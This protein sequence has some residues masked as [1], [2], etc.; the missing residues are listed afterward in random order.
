MIRFS[1][2][3]EQQSDVNAS[4]NLMKDC[5]VSISKKTNFIDSIK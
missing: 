2:I 4:I 1:I 5:K 3:Q